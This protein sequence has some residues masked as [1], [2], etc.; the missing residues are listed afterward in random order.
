MT[1]DALNRQTQVQDALGNYATTVY[2]DAGNVTTSVDQL[3]H[4]TSYSYDALN[5]RTSVQDAL[6]NFT[7]TSYDAAG[8]VQSV[9]NARGYIT[10][11]SY[12]VLNRK[13]ATTDAL[14]NITTLRLDAVGNVLTVT[15][16]RLSVTSYSYDALNHQVSQTDALNHTTTSVFDKAGNRIATVD[17]LN[18]RTSYGYDTLNRQQ[19]VTDAGGGI[20]TTVYDAAGNVVNK[21]DQ[22]GNK[23][24]FTFDA[25]NRQ[26][27][28]QDAL[29]NYSTVVYDAVGNQTVVVDQDGNRT[30]FTFD[31]LN[32]VTQETDPLGV[33]GTFAYDAASRRTSQT[34]RL[35]QRRNFTYDNA[36]RNTGETW[37]DS[38]ANTTNI[39]TN[40]FDAN[41]NKTVASDANG[42]YTFTFDA[43]D[44]VS[45]QQGPWG[46]TLTY[47]LDAVGNR[48]QVQDSFGGYVTSTYNAVNLLTSRKFITGTTAV[49]FDQA[50]DARNALTT[51]TRYSDLGGT[52]KVGD[53]IQ[54]YDAV[55]RVINIL[56]RDS[57]TTS[58]LNL[59]YTY[60][61]ASRL[62]TEVADGTTTT[63][64]YDA[65]NQV[66]NDGSAYSFDAAGNRNM[67]G[68][69]TSTGNRM[70]NDG[71]YTYTYDANSN[72]TKKSKS[73]T[74][75]TWN[76]GYDVPNRMT[77]L[78]EHSTDGGTLTLKLTE[79]YDV[80][81]RRIEE[82]RWT[83]AT[84]TVVTRFSYDNNNVTFDLDNSNALSTRYIRPDGQ[85][86]LAAKIAGS[87]AGWYVTD[88]Q[89]SVRANL[90]S[91]GAVLNKNT[92]NGFGKLT[93]QTSAAN[94]D[95][96][97]FTGKENQSDA[98][99]AYY[100]NRWYDTVTA[101]WITADPWEFAAGDDNLFRYV[102]NNPVNST[103]PTGLAE[104]DPA[105]EQADKPQRPDAK[106]DFSSS[107][108]R[109]G[110]A[111]HIK[112]LKADLKVM[113]EQ[114]DVARKF[115]LRQQQQRWERKIV[116][117]QETIQQLE[118]GTSVFRLSEQGDTKQGPTA[119]NKTV[120]DAF[121]A[122]LADSDEFLNDIRRRRNDAFNRMMKDW[123]VQAQA[124]A[125]ERA[126]RLHARRETFDDRMAGIL[127]G[128]VAPGLSRVER[129]I[130]K[131]VEETQRLILQYQRERRPHP[132]LTPEIY[133]TEEGFHR[134]ARENFWLLGLDA[135]NMM[136]LFGSFGGP[137]AGLGQAF[138]RGAAEVP[139][140]V[141]LSTGRTFSTLSAAEAKS[142]MRILTIFQEQSVAGVGGKIT[143]EVVTWQ[144]PV[145]VS[146][147]GTVEKVL[148]R[149][150]EDVNLKVLGNQIAKQNGGRLGEFLLTE[151]PA[152]R[153]ARLTTRADEIQSVLKHP[154]ELNGRT[155]A[156]LETTGGD[157]V[158]G[159]VRDLSP[160]QRAALKPGEIAAKLPHEHA[161]ITVLQEAAK[162]GL[163]PKA[164]G[165]S[166][167]F[168]PD[169][170]KALEE[171][172]ATITGP[173]TAIW[174]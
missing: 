20:A 125:L 38:G 111:E 68:Y 173:R 62:T 94:S 82:D 61:L 76:Y 129:E 121:R 116:E 11:Y 10:S 171:A 174:K 153:T 147:G 156:V 123:E 16:P 36:N 78:E 14:N 114:L 70:T 43:L 119:R 77:S 69:T 141:V 42:T 100:W 5:R 170:I 23:T 48:T 30:S 15:D 63:Y 71:T 162:R 102:H 81:N 109:W 124:D 167:D 18:Y 51:I 37:L 74:D 137:K 144:V 135:L 39:V 17:A 106:A 104:G 89:L 165:T 128:L 80:F 97:G 115:G 140:T 59:T 52:N 133:Y 145:R 126:R 86:A 105:A 154:A 27:Q 56:T 108:L 73:A 44:R 169:C 110:S 95:R 122:P 50:C 6:A 22:L 161:E 150:V 168:C 72:R 88:R 55:G 47:T 54:T 26:T 148:V 120:Q 164:I 35:G 101:R 33:S 107:G 98:L 158:G 130:G 40:T 87:T 67:S 142:G 160:A 83:N 91:T 84:G 157:I 9:T 24:T 163:K 93:N 53:T 79:K 92:Y 132:L 58:L 41:G 34:D 117:Q 96:M 139:G 118:S 146:V 25:L 166:R 31:A 99:L 152:A 66:T 4:R 143:T 3:A 7:T 29:G 65:I 90:S 32:R 64:S 151:A 46:V 57:S 1:F 159:G 155:A 149:S 134:F 28:V 45:A 103:D 131:D 113:Q 49:R 13:A 85:D 138:E 127:G 136:L 12:D 172:G 60:D 112:G 21:I 19:S 2:D 8:N 75:D